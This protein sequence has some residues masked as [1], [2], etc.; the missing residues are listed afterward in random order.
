VTF[1]NNSDGTVS[2]TLAKGDDVVIFTQ[3]TAP[4]LTI[5]PA[6]GDG[7]RYWGLP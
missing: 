3:G 2:I 4:D 1:T 7:K 6:T 5:A